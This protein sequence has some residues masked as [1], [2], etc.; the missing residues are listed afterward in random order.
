MKKICK[1]CKYWVISEIT[2]TLFAECSCCKFKY[3]RILLYHQTQKLS[4]DCLL[5]NDFTDFQT[6]ANFGCIHWKERVCDDKE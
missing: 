1:N 6:G 5:Y 2:E 3:I 4:A